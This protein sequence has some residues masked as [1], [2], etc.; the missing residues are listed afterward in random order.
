[1]VM[2]DWFK[3]KKK[4]ELIKVLEEH[5][6]YKK[7]IDYALKNNQYEDKK[8][9]IKKFDFNI[10]NDVYL[11]IKLKDSYLEELKK[12]QIKEY[13]VVSFIVFLLAL[14]VSFFLSKL[15]N[16]M[17]RTIS[18][19]DNRL[20]ETSVLV[21]LSY[22]K[23]NP[24]DK[25]I[26]FDDNFFNLLAYENIEKRSYKFDELKEFFSEE[27]LNQ[28]KTKISNIKDEDSFEFESITKD[29]NFRT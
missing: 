2:F 24:K 20:K 21:K 27:I 1:M 4:E 7:E 5:F 28:L 10:S 11:L 18:K 25:L 3:P 14:I 15:F 23:Y 29:L 16:S 17:S 13:I 9:F 8:V 26:T 6:E 12:E 19:T 22:Y